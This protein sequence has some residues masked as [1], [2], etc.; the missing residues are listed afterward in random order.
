MPLTVTVSGTLQDIR[1]RL[2]S[3]KTVC[4][5]RSTSGYPILQHDETWLYRVTQD[6]AGACPT[7]TPFDGSTYRGDYLPAEFPFLEA[8]SPV[9]VSVHNETEF[10]M[11]QRCKCTAVWVDPHEV[12]VQRL[13]DELEA[14]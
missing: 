3:M 13:A 11:A 7:C 9:M 8:S 6:P 1:S 4:A 5:Q 14:T 10:H 12:L 2:L